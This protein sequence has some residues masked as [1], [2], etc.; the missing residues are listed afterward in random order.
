[1]A[2]LDLS[3]TQPEM[4]WSDTTGKALTTDAIGGAL[5]E[6]MYR[7]QD[8]DMLGVLGQYLGTSARVNTC[9]RCIRG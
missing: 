3:T 1:M 2:S 8:T 6:M 5:M 7:G 4:N 9:L